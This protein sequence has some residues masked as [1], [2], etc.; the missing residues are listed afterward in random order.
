ME[1]L[2]EQSRQRDGEIRKGGR[3][4]KDLY[5][6]CHCACGIESESE[7]ESMPTHMNY[8]VFLFSHAKSFLADVVFFVGISIGASSALQAHEVVGGMLYFDRV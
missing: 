3:R 8:R 2:V 6:P 4:G 1:I 5:R 7:S